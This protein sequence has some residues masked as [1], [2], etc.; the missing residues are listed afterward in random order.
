MTVMNALSFEND[1]FRGYITWGG[2]LMI[3]MLLMAFLTG[4]QRFRKGVS[5]T[6]SSISAIKSLTDEI[7]STGL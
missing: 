3:K 2:L 7:D 1:V 4:V 6:L 5:V